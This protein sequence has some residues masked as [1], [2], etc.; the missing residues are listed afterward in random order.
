MLKVELVNG[1]YQ[2]ITPDTGVPVRFYS[3]S[4]ATQAAK[5]Y[6]V[7]KDESNKGNTLA[8]VSDAIM[9]IID[10]IHMATYYTSRS[11]IKEQIENILSEYI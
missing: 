1:M 3:E 9:A 11:D 10:G 4:V 6:Y 8:L 7:A 2:F 5:E